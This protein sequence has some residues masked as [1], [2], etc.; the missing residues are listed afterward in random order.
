MGESFKNEGFFI[1][2]NLRFLFP[3]FYS[4]LKLSKVL[5]S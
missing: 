2:F 4:G 1:D 5:S 3:P